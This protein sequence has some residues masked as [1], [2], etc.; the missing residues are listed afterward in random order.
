MTAQLDRRVRARIDELLATS[1]LDVPA[2]GEAVMQL[3]DETRRPDGDLRRVAD[4]VRRDPALAGNL[5]KVA[6]SVA[7]AG[8]EPA[9]TLQQVVSRLGVL[10]LRN[11]ALLIATQSRAFRVTGRERQMRV[12]FVRSFATALFAQDIARMRRLGVE[13]AFL[14]GLFHDVGLPIVLQLAIDVHAELG[15]APDPAAID[16]LADEIHAEAGARAIE[17]WQLG[18]KLADAVR[19][20]HDD[21][22]DNRGAAIVGLACALAT[23]ALEPSREA[24]AAVRAHP[25]PAAL[26]LYRD[27]VDR[28]IAAAPKV[29][30]QVS[31]AT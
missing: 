24:E 13:E 20:H 10:A 2:L 17:S 26:G 7:Y 19:H 29:A 15:V 3:V 18:A 9:I 28:L 27:D 11:L 5:L 25:A 4:I 21:A 1:T 23:V 30:V 22:T 8:R 14:A 31:E 16:A 6:N 12:L